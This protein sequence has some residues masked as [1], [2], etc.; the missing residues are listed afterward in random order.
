MFIPRHVVAYIFVRQ[1]VDHPRAAGAVSR[2]LDATAS[3]AAI[4]RGTQAPHPALVDI[5]QRVEVNHVINIV[6]L[7]SS[8]SST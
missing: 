8:Y 7:V 4:S 3:S 5:F 2:I 1:Q 6:S